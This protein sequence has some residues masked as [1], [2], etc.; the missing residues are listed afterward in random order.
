MDKSQLA[1]TM[2]NWETKYI[3]L[4]MLELA[5]KE[6]V[7]ELEE[8]VVTGNVR[9]TYRKPRKTYDYKA[10]VAGNRASLEI[11]LVAKHTET[12]TTTKTD[13]Q[14]IC[15]EAQVDVP[16]TEGEPSVTIKRE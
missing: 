12:F 16:F 2:L 3:E 9:A 11:G 7:L 6:A 8:T 14:A 1:Q 10:G 15:K 13:Y 4:V 5:I